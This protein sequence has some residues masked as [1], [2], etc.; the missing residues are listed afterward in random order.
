MV[1]RGTHCPKTTLSVYLRLLRG[2]VSVVRKSTWAVSKKQKVRGKPKPASHA[3]ILFPTIALLPTATFATGR[4]GC[5]LQIIEEELRHA[6]IEM[7][8]R[9]AA[10]DKVVAV[11]VDLHLKL[12]VGLYQSFRIFRAIAVVYIVVGRTVNEQ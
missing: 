10:I 1:A 2:A 11:G 12:L 6:L 5:V 9:V 8:A 7:Q 4:K 3:F